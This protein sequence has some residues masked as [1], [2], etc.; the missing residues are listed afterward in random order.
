MNINP[1]ILG[2]PL[3]PKLTYNKHIEVTITKARKPI[4][5]GKALTSTTWGKQKETMLATYKSITKSILEYVS[6]IWSPLTSDTNINKLQITQNTALIITT[7]CT[8]DTTHTPST[9]RNTHNTHKQTSPTT[10]ITDKTKITTP[11]TPTTLHHITTQQIKLRHKKQ[12]PYNNT[13]YTTHIDINPNTIDDAKIKTNRK[14]IH[15]TIV[16]PYL[17]NRQHNKV[18]N[19]IPLTIHHSETTLPSATRHTL[20]QLRTNKCPLLRS[21]LN[22]RQPPI[23]TMPYLH[24][25]TT[26]NY[27]LVQLHQHTT[28]CHG[29]VDGPH[30]CGE[31]AG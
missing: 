9:R 20:V 30:G 4:H 8:A 14:H 19:T 18:T 24:I 1:K 5:I 31:P 23:T 11:H 2:L 21:Y 7:W 26:H 6:T 27:T 15:T 12:I 17:N 29:F 25:R 28:K 22:K 16:S 3:D 10:R 13:D